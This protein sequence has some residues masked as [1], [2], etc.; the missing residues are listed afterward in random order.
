MSEES[1]STE[2]AETAN[3]EEVL[4]EAHPA[5][6]RARPFSFILCCILV[7]VIV[8]AIIL[9]V[10]WLQCKRTTLTVTTSRTR[11]RRGLLSV[12]K[13]EVWHDHVRNVKIE[14]TAFERIMGVGTIGIASAGKSDFEIKVSGLPKINEIKDII[15]RNR[16]A[17]ESSAD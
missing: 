1:E 12:Y 13:T 14:Q 17:H 9:F 15:D 11:Y 10:W 7:L 8:G 4:Y 5:M 6:F 16:I 2:L 3:K